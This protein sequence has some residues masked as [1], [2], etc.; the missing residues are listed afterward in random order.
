MLSVVRR[1]FE[2]H[3]LK[4]GYRPPSTRPYHTSSALRKPSRS[5]ST[6]LSDTHRRGRVSASTHRSTPSNASITYVDT[7]DIGSASP[8][9]SIYAPSPKRSI[10]LGIFTSHTQTMPLPPPFALPPRTSSVDPP[11]AIFQPTAS[12]QNLPLPPRMSALVSPSGFVPSSIPA[13]Y[14]ASAWRAVHPLAPSPLGPVASRSLS[15]LP[16]MNNFT[17]R[18][19]QSRSS[20]S[21]TRPYRLSSTNPIGSEGW[22]SRSDSDGPDEGRGSPSSGDGCLEYRA[23][24]SEIAYAILNATWVPGTNSA[25]NRTKGHVRHLSAPDVTVGT[26]QSNSRMSKGWKPQLKDRAERIEVPSLKIPRSSSADLLSR[27]SPD[28]SPDDEGVSLRKELEKN[29]FMRLNSEV[30]LPLRKIQSADPLRYSP[31]PPMAAANLWRTSTATNRASKTSEVDTGAQVDE[32][33]AK[34]PFDKLK[35]KPL[36]KIAML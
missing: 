16:H 13:Q 28:T 6:S 26:E 18:N 8:P 31:S 21:L 4:H 5:R 19:R 30:F 34:M 1:P 32:E 2:A 9:S 7:L 22:S 11:P 23:S 25:R 36:P 35:N 27:F 33:G 10:G 3:L 20:I 14:S 15:H 17:Y 24:P 29:L 12:N